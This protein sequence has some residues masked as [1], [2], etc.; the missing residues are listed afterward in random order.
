MVKRRF[1]VTTDPRFDVDQNDI[2]IVERKG[3]G[4]PDS[5]TDSIAVL[6]SSLYSK[7]TLEHFNG[8]A[9]HNIDKVVISG[10]AAEVKFGDGQ[11]TEP[12]FVNFVGRAI[13]EFTDSNKSNSKVQKLKKVPLYILAKNAI[14]QVFNGIVPSLEYLYDVN[15]VKRGSDDLIAN[16]ETDN[17]V[18][19]AND[20]SFATS[21]APLSHVENMVTSLETYLN[22]EYRQR[23]SWLGPDIK[24]MARRID[25]EIILNVAAAFI[26]H[27]IETPEEYI[28]YRSQLHEDIAKFVKL[29]LENIYVNT[30]D[31]DEQNVF[32]LTV[33]GTS[34]EQGDDGAVG[35]G[36]R[37]T[38]VIAPYRPQTLEAI[39]GKN[40]NKHVGNFY[41]VWATLIARKIYEELGVKNTVA[42]VST[43]GKPITDCDIF[44]TTADEANSSDIQAIAEEIIQNYQ[45]ITRKIID[46]DLDM[47]PFY[48]IP[49]K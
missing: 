32:Y 22:T 15:E 21:W 27:E 13:R 6:I 2:E 11:Q 37:I 7:Y 30:A 16:Y 47:Y 17:E 35:R 40:P 1:R 12:V 18:P 48:Y 20:T 29:P 36:N 44:I 42:L 39:A 19:H 5:L 9:H 41:N 8:I 34:L 4:H 23:H 14:E 31:I 46:L 28:N 33:T 43:I 10:G 38:G 25:D 45:I 24:I 3:M 26:A 49:K